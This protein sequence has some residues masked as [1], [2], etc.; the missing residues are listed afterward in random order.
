MVSFVMKTN[1]PESMSSV[2]TSQGSQ[3]SPATRRML[4]LGLV[5][6]MVTLA[7]VAIL[8]SVAAPSFANILRES[9]LTTAS[10]EL[11]AA[12]FLT[13]STAITQGRRV[14]ICTS[15]DGE[16]CES[17]IGW[18][19]GWIVFADLNNNGIRDPE[20]TVLRAGGQQITGIRMQGNTPVRNYVSYL[21]NGMTR[22]VNGALQ[23]GT[24]TA[25]S[26][27]RARQIVI[28]AAGR[29]RVVRDAAC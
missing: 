25:C 10:N 22:A 5:E 8:L 15:A 26:D 13:R 20:E 23:M 7:V 6:L 21:P 9:R 28:S 24:I 11:L 3:L 14:T 27:G 18:D 17:G 1:A 19:A 29:P 2:F 16:V 4:G 12:L